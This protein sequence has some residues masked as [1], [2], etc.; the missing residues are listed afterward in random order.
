MSAIMERIPRASLVAGALGAIVLVIGFIVAPARAAASYLIAYTACLGVALGALALVMIARVTAAN[1]FVALRRQAEHVMAT[2]PA[3]AV[4]V[5]PVLLS[6]HLLYPWSTPARLEPA[7]RAAVEAKTAYL[8]TPFFVIR[9]IIYVIAWVLLAE[10]LRNASLAQDRGEG[11]RASREMYLLSAGGLIVSAV[12]VSFASF[13]W[14]MSLTP[15]WYSTIYGVDYF[16]G[17]MVSAL[18]A[19]AVIVAM[20]RRTAEIP[21]AVGSDHFHALAKLLLTFVLFWVYIGFAQYIVVWSGEIPAER[22]WYAVRSR[23]GWRVVAEILILGHFAL[24][25]CLLLVQA[26]KRS[27]AI[28]AALGAWLLV[29]HYVDVYW[30][31][32][33]DAPFSG[34]WGFV[35]DA[36]ALAFVG[37]A[38]S[39]A[40]AVRRAGIA[41]VPVADPRLAASLQYRTD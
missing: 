9:S 2:L 23:G 17:A 3:F 15:A 31:A 25:F 30:I 5:I 18:A 12:T 34:G 11:E 8:N 37:G 33:P 20:E 41:V 40:W 32:M 7:A 16:A 27:V 10:R 38:A 21:A 28:M 14:L 19:L 13:D 35:T 39:A 24:P 29:M 1:W 36:A 22:V 6:M 26:L 4:L